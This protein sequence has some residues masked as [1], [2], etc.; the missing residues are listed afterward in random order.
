MALSDDQ[1]DFIR[2]KTGYETGSGSALTDAMF[3]LLET[4]EESIWGTNTNAVV[5]AV[6][7][8]VVDNLLMQA[9]KRN[10]YKQNQ[11]TESAGQIF[12][13]LHKARK[14]FSDALD[15]ATDGLMPAVQFGGLR[16]YNKKTIEV[17]NDYRFPP[18][19]NRD[20]S[21]F[22]GEGSNG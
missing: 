13:H 15:V 4:E 8:D 2:F 19:G 21:R 5:A 16:R 7:L 12:D 20:L 6:G 22:E 14:F 11:S 9:A 17:P 18:T 1:R 10:D 3:T